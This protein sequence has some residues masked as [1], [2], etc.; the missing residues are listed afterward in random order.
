MIMALTSEPLRVL[1]RLYLQL[2]FDHIEEERRKWQAII[3]LLNPQASLAQEAQ[4]YYAMLIKSPR[5]CPRLQLV[6]RQRGFVDF[7][8]WARLWQTDIEMLVEA[9]TFASTAL[10]RLQ[11]KYFDRYFKLCSLA[12]LRLPQEQRKGIAISTAKTPSCCR[13]PG[14]MRTVVENVGQ[15]AKDAAGVAGTDDV[16]RLLLSLVD[17][18]FLVS[19][20][21]RLSIAVCERLH[22]LNR[23]LSV[24]GKSTYAVLAAKSLLTRARERF[25]RWMAAHEKGSET[26]FAGQ[27]RIESPN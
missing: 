2:S 19:W 4:R 1:T 26:R 25:F 3:D 7:A 23:N 17:T 14:L 9:V 13:A 12:D 16:V 15:Q 22:A 5:A 24:S 21:L 6:M 10:D 8:E 20:F 27:A 11:S 18:L